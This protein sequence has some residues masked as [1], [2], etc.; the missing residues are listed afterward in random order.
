MMGEGSHDENNEMW[1]V[2]PLQ[3]HNEKLLLRSFYTALHLMT[4]QLSTGPSVK[5]AKSQPNNPHLHALGAVLAE[6]RSPV[7]T[8]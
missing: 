1:D 8:R 5:V 6:Q 3:T 2:S 4:D 7:S